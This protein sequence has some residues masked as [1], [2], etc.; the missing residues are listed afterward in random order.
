M[1]HIV[2]KI[3]AYWIAQI[4]QRNIRIASVCAA[5]LNIQSEIRTGQTA[6]KVWNTAKIS[7]TDNKKK[8]ND[9]YLAKT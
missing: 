8:E 1:A 4:R 7:P 3:F 6:A 5:K 9:H 2:T